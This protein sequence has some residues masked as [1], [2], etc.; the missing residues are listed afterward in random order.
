VKEEA[1]P[2]K[3]GLEYNAEIAKV[4]R[5]NAAAGVTLKDTFAEIQHMAWAPRSMTT[6]MKKYGQDW[7]STK[8]SIAAKIGNRVVTQA[9][10][11][12]IDHPATWKSQELYLR[13]HGGWSPKSTEQ[14][15]E[16]GT[17]EEE[18]ESAVNS[19]M[20]LLGKD[21]EEE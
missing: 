6:L 11:G 3:H 13:S 20:K 15:Q 9:I 1:M 21:S 2:P 4:V 19:L 5:R 18:A 12:D 14:T 7:H 17:E 8:A 16:V 10:E